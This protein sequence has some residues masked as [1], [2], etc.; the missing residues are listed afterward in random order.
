MDNIPFIETGSGEQVLHFAHANAYPPGTYRQF[1]DAL[2]T[3]YR[4]L[5]AEHRPMW[6]T[7]DPWESLTGWHVIANDLI[8]FLDSHGLSGVIGAGHSLGGVATFYAALERPDL[9][10]KLVLIDPVFLPPEYVVMADRLEPMD[11]P[12]V[13]GAMRRRNGWESREAMFAHYR[14]KKVFARFTDQAL[15]DFCQS[16]HNRA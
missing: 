12:L 10:S 2:G 3:Q 1:L 8:R 9:F 15:W 4:V 11:I 5:A 6:D 14:P 7:S 16:W 13:K